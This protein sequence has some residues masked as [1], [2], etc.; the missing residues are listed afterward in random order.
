MNK[1]GR[2]IG[3]FVLLLISAV[4]APWEIWRA[5]EA[6]RLDKLGALRQAQAGVALIVKQNQALSNQLQDTRSNCLSEEDLHELARLRAEV[7]RCRATE[8]EMEKLRAANERT[9]LWLAARP[10]P[11][12]EPDRVRT[13]WLKTQLAPAGDAD[14]NAALQT[15]LCAMSRNDPAALAACVTPEAWTNLTRQQWFVHDPPAVEL[16]KAAR[17]IADSL[18]PDTGFAVIDEH[19]AGGNQATVQLYFEGEGRTRPCVLR[20]IDGAWKF[21]RLGGVWP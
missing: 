4:A 17:Q 5:G 2:Q 3:F 16:A 11:A 12:P 19:L 21:D 13:R 1:N 15:T 10:L 6:Q 18:A 7:E 8:A 14:I 9:R 20:K